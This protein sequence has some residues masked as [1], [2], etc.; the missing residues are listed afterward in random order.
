[1]EQAKGGDYSC[2]ILTSLCE[3]DLVIAR[4]EIEVARHLLAGEILGKVVCRGRD[5]GISDS[6]SVHVYGHINELVLAI[7]L[8]HEES[9]IPVWAVA[10]L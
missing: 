2:Y 3:R 9:G 6:D 4:E 8:A 7:L 5:Y 10:F 1:M